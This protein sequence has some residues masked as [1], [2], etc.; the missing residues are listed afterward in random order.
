MSFNVIDWDKHYENNRTRAMRKMEW[1]P[2]PNRHD[3]DGYTTL[4]DHPNG[5]AHFGAW[6]ALIE[7]ASRC[8]VRGTLLRSC[9]TPYDAA[10]L[11]RVTRIPA[12]IWDE[13]LPRLL[14]IGWIGDYKIQHP[15]AET[16]EGIQ[17]PPA[18]TEGGTQ[19]GPAA[20]R[21]QGE[22]NGT[23]RNGTEIEPQKP[24][25]T[26]VAA[27]EKDLY[28]Y[29]SVEKAFLSKNDDKFTD[30]GKEGK[31]IYG[32]IKKA[33]GRSPD[34][35]TDLLRE[36]THRFWKLRCTDDKFWKGQPFL[37]SALNASGIWDRVLETMRNEERSADPVAMAIAKGERL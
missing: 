24:P 33:K 6:C 5:A 18:E 28:L 29:H 20:S 4:L 30:Y 36:M 37:P 8:A 11:E 22:R 13:A 15:P 14:T 19:Q 9:G 31:A 27:S 16:D 12:A 25:A 32:L 1:V 3:G 34:N 2:M 10:S 23:E 7:V 26:S 35:P 21:A 17:H